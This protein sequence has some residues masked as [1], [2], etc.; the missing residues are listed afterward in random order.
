LGWQRLDNGE[1]LNKAA[2]QFD[3]LVTMDKNMPSQQFI[4]GY[5]IAVVIVK[6]RS[7]RIGDLTPL[8]PRIQAAIGGGTPGTATAVS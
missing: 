7:N 5:S 4:Q 3:V 8:V 6:A 1:L 2:G